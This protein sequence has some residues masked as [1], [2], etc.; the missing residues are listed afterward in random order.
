MLSGHLTREA[1][2]TLLQSREVTPTQQRIEIAAIL[3]ERPQHLTA[4]EVLN[5]VNRHE[6]QVS[7]ATVYNTLGL[8]ARKGLV[9]EVIVDPTK[10]VYDSNTRPHHHL[11]DITTGNLTDVDADAIRIGGLPELP[12]GVVVEGVDVVIRIRGR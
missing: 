9:R 6:A 5:R 11:Y 10:V 2:A 7:K 4:E 12:D 8:F 3:L 1:I